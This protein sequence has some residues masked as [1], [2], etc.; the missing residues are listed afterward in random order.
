MI[1]ASDEKWRTFNCF[2][3]QGT[4]GSLKGSDLEN[5]VGD[6]DSG[7]P[8]K[9]INS[10]LQVTGET[11]HC[12]TR[13]IPPSWNSREV[14]PSKCPSIAPV[15]MS[16]TPR[17][18][19]GPL[20][21]NQWGGCRLD[22]KK[23]ETR[24]STADFYTLNFWGRGDSTCRHS[25]DCYFVSGSYWYNQVLSMVTNRARQEIIWIGL[26]KFQMLLTRMAPLKFLIRVQA[27]Q[28]PLRRELPH[29]QIFMNNAPNPLTWD[30][31]L[32]SY[33]FSRNPT[34]FQD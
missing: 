25:I 13:T 1:S 4:G 11:G 31:Q 15:K 16:N 22:P 28:D 10:G 24:T 17:W 21:D 5:R 9:S 2:L 30:A 33:W 34:V 3:V 20:E 8:G 32:L 7:S 29:V 14:F 12:R 6:Q 23:I 19:F 18:L 26:K 27:F